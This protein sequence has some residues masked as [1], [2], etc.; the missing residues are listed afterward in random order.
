MKVNGISVE[1]VI[2]VFEEDLKVAEEDRMIRKPVSATLYQLWKKIERIE[3]PR[4]EE[5]R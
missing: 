5:E 1:M 4:G 2:H 3:T